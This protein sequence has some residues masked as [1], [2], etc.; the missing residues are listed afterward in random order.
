MDGLAR[1]QVQNARFLVCFSKKQV[2]EGL[3]T[4]QPKPIQ[5]PK[6]PNPQTPYP[7]WN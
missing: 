5:T 7:P 4:I 1:S 2:E 3:F 6:P